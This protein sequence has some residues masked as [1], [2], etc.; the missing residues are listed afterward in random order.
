MKWHLTTSSAVLF[1]GSVVLWA[2]DVQIVSNFPPRTS[3]EVLR[4]KGIH[5]LS[6]PSLVA[7]LGNSD[8]E[9]RR[10]AASEL[11]AEHR[12][13]SIPAIESALNR[14]RDLSV[15]VGLAETLLLL[16]DQRGGT[17]LHAMCTD[18]SVPIQ[19]VI[20]A[21]R[22]LQITHSS[23]SMCADTLLKEMSHTKEG[24]EVAMASSL[25]P[26]IYADASS[27]QARQIFATLQS[28]ILDK[29]QEA[30]VR[31]N[32]SRALVQIGGPESRATIREAISSERDPAMRSFFEDYLK[33]LEKR[34]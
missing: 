13:T 34:P 20:S 7:E 3:A 33:T 26:Q 27:S 4:A 32:S 11:A 14:E 19:F 8:P 30:I 16:G 12:D 15:Q 2:Q 5:D 29:K 24:G 28:L 25:L 23:S 9:I 17:Q 31:M 21:V 6:E 10:E 22:A 1:M 18:P